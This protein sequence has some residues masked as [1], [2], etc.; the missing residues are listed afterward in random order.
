MSRYLLAVAVATA[1]VASLFAGTAAAQPKD[2]PVSGDERATVHAGNVVDQDCAELIEGSTA[3]AS[4]DLTF[5]VDD[6]NT[7]IDITAVATGVHVGAVIVKGGPAYNV[8]EPED[9][10]DLPWEDL[11]SPLVSSG[12]P[13][14]ISHWFACGDKDT[15]E[16]TTTTPPTTTTEPSETSTT[17]TTTS[18]SVS[19]TSV[20]TTTT[21]TVAVAAAAAVDEL[22]ETGFNGGWLV[23]LAAAL[24]LAGGSLLL[25]LRLRT[26]RR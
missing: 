15:E 14:Q 16:T 17:T 22:P 20:T 11:H 8:Y 18:P 26:T 10:G 19:D 1:A 6:T 2:D 7:Y 9:L 13:A 5:S 21:S 12:K 25:L 24:L 23:V 4:G 3:I